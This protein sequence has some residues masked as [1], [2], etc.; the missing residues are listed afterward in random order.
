MTS[1]LNVSSCGR[2]FYFIACFS[3][4]FIAFCAQAQEAENDADLFS[5]IESLQDQ[6]NIQIIGL[7]K[8]G[9]EPKVSAH[10]NPEQQLLRSLQSYNHAISRNTKG[11][12]EKVVIMDK[13]QKTAA[14]R[15]ILPTHFEG[16]HFLVSVSVSGNGNFWET[17]DMIIDTGADLIVLP[18]S[19]IDKLD[20]ADS[21]F[22][23]R[24]MQTANGKVDAKIGKL[25][26][27]RIEGETI[28]DVD[29]AFVDDGLLANKSLLG[30]SA[31]GR[32]KLVIDNDSQLVT[33]F[34][35]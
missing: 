14:D 23:N 12:I 18:T 35:K 20:M 5:Q 2:L 19:M 29:A 22:I 26:S 8:I 24:Q 32:Y 11:Q 15:I 28:E 21:T 13:K 4:M 1:H 25:Q 7:E 33:L 27:V 16:G 34:K 3:Y 30:M 17:L 31:L 6:M 9:D 10:G